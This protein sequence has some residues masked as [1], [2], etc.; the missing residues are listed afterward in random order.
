MGQGFLGISTKSWIEWAPTTVLPLAAVQ[1]QPEMHDHGM[2][3]NAYQGC[4]A[5]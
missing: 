4:V 3:I 2:Q 1:H 5:I